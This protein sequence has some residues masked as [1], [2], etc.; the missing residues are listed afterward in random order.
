[1]LQMSR[2]TLAEYV[3]GLCVSSVVANIT[4]HCIHMTRRPTE[5][6]S[7][8]RLHNQR[9][10]SIGGSTQRISL[11]QRSIEGSI[12]QRNAVGRPVPTVGSPAVVISTH[13]TACCAT[14][15]LY[16]QLVNGVSLSASS[17]NPDQNGITTCFSQTAVVSA[18]GNN[19]S[20]PA[21]ILDSG[22][23]SSPSGRPS[24]TSSDY[25]SSTPGRSPALDFWRGQ[26]S[27][28]STISS[29]LS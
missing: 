5:T 26:R 11:H 17:C 18:A 12:I 9:P 6:C 8:A 10:S 7:R 14:P 15:R 29:G 4:H 16:N 24:L 28:V 13:V 23:Y 19:G 25:A 1:M 3:P 27:P 2:H 20:I 21:R 22:S